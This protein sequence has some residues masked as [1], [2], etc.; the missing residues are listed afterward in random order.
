MR[1]PTPWAAR[2]VGVVRRINKHRQRARGEPARRNVSAP[3]WC[4]RRAW[5][6]SARAVGGAL[7]GRRMRK[8]HPPPGSTRGAREAQRQRAERV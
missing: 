7:G 4:R 6:A 5:R 8:Q 3:R 1:R 2:L